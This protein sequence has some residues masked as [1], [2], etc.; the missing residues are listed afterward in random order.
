MLERWYLAPQARRR[1][2]SWSNAGIFSVCLK[3]NFKFHTAKCV[4]FAKHIRWCDHVLSAEAIS[5][6]PRRIYGIRAMD[7]SRTVWKLQQ[8]VCALQWM[9]NAIPRF[10]NLIFPLTFFLERA[11][12]HTGKR[13]KRSAPGVS[14]SKLGMV[15][16]R[17]R[18]IQQVQSVIGKWGL[19]FRRD[20]NLCLNVYM[21][22]LQG[23]YRFDLVRCVT[24]SPAKQFCKT[25]L[26]SASS[27]SFLF[28][29]ILYKSELGWYTVK[30]KAYA[31]LATTERMHL[32]LATSNGFNI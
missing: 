19:P 14:H 12:Q 6:D 4:L 28:I 3:H 5:F 27:G 29:W 21:G 2:T 8:F 26:C 25:A 13:T 32:M 9:R 15:S 16:Y 18:C 7:P 31:I 10:S 17:E 11:Y 20:P 24:P 22:C 1:G 30:K 23:R